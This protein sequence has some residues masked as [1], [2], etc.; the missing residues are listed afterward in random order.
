MTG[1]LPLDVRSVK[2]V[3][4]SPMAKKRGWTPSEMGKKG[5]KARKKALSPEDLSRIARDA[6]NVRWGNPKQKA[7]KK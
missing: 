1:T 4:C 7:G 2:H 3:F 6:A 5:G